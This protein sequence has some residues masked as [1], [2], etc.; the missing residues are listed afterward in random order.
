MEKQYMMF[1]INDS[2]ATLI[3][4]VLGNK[5]CTKILSFL[6]EKEMSETDLAKELK[7]PA[8]TVHYNVQKL[9]SAGFVEPAS[10]FFWSTKGKKIVMYKI[11]NK[12]VVISPKTSFKGILPALIGTGIVAFL[13]KVFTAS[14]NAL[15]TGASQI[16]ASTGG[17]PA[18]YYAAGAAMKVA[19]DSANA[20]A[21]YMANANDAVVQSVGASGVSPWSWF[22]LGAWCAL[23]IFVLFNIRRD[24]LN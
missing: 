7:L 16:A 2:R 8:N 6:A 14:S 22:I 19:A 1:D 4:E 13:V 18:E 11:S 24:S 15:S 23:L 3:A 9:V 12:K 20:A 5:T 21:P 10:K 17:A